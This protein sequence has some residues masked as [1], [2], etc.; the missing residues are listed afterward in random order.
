VE[1]IVADPSLPVLRINDRSPFVGKMQG[2]MRA[3]KHEI[4]IDNRFGPDTHRQLADYQRA[5]GL[6]PD[7]VCGPKTWTSLILNP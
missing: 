4:A 1:T 2:L 5:R 3:A 7:S 6:K